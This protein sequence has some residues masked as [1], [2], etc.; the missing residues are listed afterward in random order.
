MN[1]NIEKLRKDLMDYFGTASF[2]GFP[3]ASMDLISVENASNEELIQIA[4]NNN[5]DLN[6]YINNEYKKIL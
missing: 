2:N 4:L 3:I 1:I 6:N 5:F